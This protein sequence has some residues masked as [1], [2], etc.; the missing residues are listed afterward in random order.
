MQYNTLRK[1]LPWVILSTTL[2]TT[3]SA[4]GN[5]DTHT[6]TLSITV[7]LVALIDVED[8]SPT[9]TFIAPMNAGEG[10]TG[11]QNSTNNQPKIAV[12]SNNSSAKLNVR[13]DTDLSPYG[14]S[15]ALTELSGELGSCISNLRLT[16]SDSTLCNLGMQ[17]TTNGKVLIL[18]NI[19]S[20]NTMIPYGNYT[21]NI[22]YTISEN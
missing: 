5:S 19:D 21:S 11:I 4:L 20:T 22:I 2:G 15:I 8:I 9:F 16:T 3:H 12:S 13:L 10:F 7:P 14:F 6:Q 17:Q 18:A 1:T